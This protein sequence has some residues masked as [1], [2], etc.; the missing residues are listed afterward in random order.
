[1]IPSTLPATGTIDISALLASG[2]SF[3]RV[4]K[5]D[6]IFSEGSHCSFYHQLVS[7][8]V[9]WVNIDDDGR[10]YV[11]AF[12]EPGECFGEMPLF[13]DG[14]YASSAFAEQDCLIIRLKKEHFLQMMAENNKLLMAMGRVLAQ[15]LRYRFFLLKTLTN[16][17]PEVRIERLFDYLKQ[18]G[19]HICNQTG[20]LNLKRQQIADLCGL[21]VETVIRTILHM[22]ETGAL[23]VQDRKIYLSKNSLPGFV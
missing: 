8:S 20:Q 22:H 4:A 6:L 21:R 18:E 9:R 1:M 16:P 5:G 3:K 7:G 2:A 12:I 13:D 17:S 23:L 19:R 15:R 11:Q 10:T 14:P